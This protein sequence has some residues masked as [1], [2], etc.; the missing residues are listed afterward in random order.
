MR[1][2]ELYRCRVCGLEHSDPPWGIDGR[3]PSYEYCA[4]CGV[5]FGYGDATP[6]AAR[7]TRSRWLATGAEWADADERPCGWLV[8]DQLC[9]VPEGYRDRS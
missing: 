7:K 2:E 1:S 6:G 3:T 4:C 8:D 9:G 5:E